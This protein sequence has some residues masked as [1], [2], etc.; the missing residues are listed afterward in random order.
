M[1]RRDTVLLECGTAGPPIVVMQARRGN[2]NQSFEW[3]STWNNS[4]GR[5]CPGHVFHV[6]HTA[7]AVAL[8]YSLMLQQYL[9]TIVVKTPGRG[10]HDI[11]P[12]VAEA[13]RDG[14]ALDG[15]AT[16]FLRHTSASLVIQEN[17]DP[18]VL[19]DLERF[20]QRLVPDGDPLYCHRDEGPDDMPAHVRAAMTAVQ[21]SV[22]LTSGRLMLGTWQAIY[23]WEQRTR[24]HRREIVIHVVGA[25]SSATR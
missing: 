16:L 23:L 13:V 10:L 2:S 21:V 18:D 25:P 9:S 15:L 3:C 11:T 7:L 4:M 22:P 1:A 14:G 20:M 24:P 6:E 17:A 19:G 12:T 5:P 8:A